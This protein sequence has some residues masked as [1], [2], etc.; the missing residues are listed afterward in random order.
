[1]M[2]DDVSYFRRTQ[3][4]FENLQSM[5]KL[6]VVF[7]V[8]SAKNQSFIMPGQEK[9]KV[10]TFGERERKGKLHYTD[11]LGC[12]CHCPQPISRIIYDQHQ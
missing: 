5:I 11:Y 4:M 9:G 6:Q 7:Q 8:V 12:M 2:I 1:M 10:V 3:R